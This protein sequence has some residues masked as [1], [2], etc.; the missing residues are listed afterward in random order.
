MKEKLKRYTEREIYVQAQAA[1]ERRTQPKPSRSMVY[2]GMRE[3][4]VLI[5][6]EEPKRV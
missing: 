3:S 4:D 2:A 5:E 1:C 6:R